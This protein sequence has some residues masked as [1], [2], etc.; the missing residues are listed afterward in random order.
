MRLQLRLLPQIE[1]KG[2]EL[3]YVLSTCEVIQ[4]LL[5]RHEVKQEHVGEVIVKVILSH[6]TFCPMGG[7]M[8]ATRSRVCLGIGGMHKCCHNPPV[9]RQGR[10]VV[11]TLASAISKNLHIMTVFSQ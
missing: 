1:I 9:E 3:G 4:T 7:G 6:H 11:T 2:C 10:R 5:Q 8:G